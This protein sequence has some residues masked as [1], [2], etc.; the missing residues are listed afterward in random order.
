MG[1]DANDFVDQI[2]NRLILEGYSSSID[3][4]GDKLE[5]KI[6]NA[7]LANYNFIGVVGKEELKN[8]TIDVRDRDKNESIGK[9]SFGELIKLFKSLEPKPSKRRQALD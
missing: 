8:Q 3:N 1:N 6:R 9:L 2:N 7:Q 5:K 4:S